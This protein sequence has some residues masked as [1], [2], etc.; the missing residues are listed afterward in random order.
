M[1]IVIIVIITVYL[2]GSGQ[3]TPDRRIK[4]MIMD[5][6]YDYYYNDYIDSP[7]CTGALKHD[8]YDDYSDDYYDYDYDDDDYSEPS[9]HTCIKE[10]IIMMIIV[11]IIMIM[12]MMTTVS[13]PC[14]LALKKLLL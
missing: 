10:M 5:D 7:P 11:M 4:D 3:P 2:T 12:M 13:P 9:L 14:T 6:Y 8:Y 1:I